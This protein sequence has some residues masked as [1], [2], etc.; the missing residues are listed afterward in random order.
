VGNKNPSFGK[1]DYLLCNFEKPR[2]I[3][4]HFVGDACKAGNIIGNVTFRINKCNEFIRDI[5]AVVLNDGNLGY[6]FDP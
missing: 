3:S 1:F 5:A 4:N 2:G 6:F